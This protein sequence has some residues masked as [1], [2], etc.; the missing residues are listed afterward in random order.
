VQEHP[1]EAAGRVDQARAEKQ[2]PRRY[3]GVAPD[4]GDPFRQG[5]PPER[6]RRGGRVAKRRPV[7][8]ERTANPPAPL[9]TPAPNSIQAV[10]PSQHRLL[11]YIVGG[12]LLLWGC[13]CLLFSRS[14][15]YAI[16]LLA[17]AATVMVATVI[18]GAIHPLEQQLRRLGA[19][20]LQSESWSMSMHALWR[21]QEGSS[22]RAQNVE[23]Q[24]ESEMAKLVADD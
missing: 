3:Q 18:V 14:G 22:G 19:C 11:W 21:P 8:A 7:R 17:S 1:I 10:S 24:R 9:P 12:S 13:R 4:S 15:I 16:D 23:S 2:E 6:T 5:A 20:I